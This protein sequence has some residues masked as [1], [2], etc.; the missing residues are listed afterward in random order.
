MSKLSYANLSP[1]ATSYSR[2]QE[3]DECPR[4]WYIKNALG[5]SGDVVTTHTNFAYG[6]AVATGIQH[7]IEKPE[8]FGIAIVKAMMQWNLPFWQEDTKKKKSI[9]FVIEVVRRF[10]TLINSQYANPFK[11]FELAWFEKDGKQIPAVELTFLVH[12]P[13]GYSYEG[14]IDLVL[15]EK[16]THNYVVL[17]L[18]TTSFT[19]LSPAIY[20]NSIQALGYAIVLDQIAKD[21]RQVSAY[22]V[23]YWVVKSSALEFQPFVFPKNFSKR[24]GFINHLLAKIEIMELYRELGYYPMHGQSCYSFFSDC[25]LLN[26]CEMSDETLKLMAGKKEDHQFEEAQT[27]P[28]FIFHWEALVHTQTQLAGQ[29]VIPAVQAS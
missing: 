8:E 20:Q 24:I 23:F 7:L 9:W 3:F 14:H 27:P 16:G 22:S 4:K 12:L 13:K 28:D 10:H 17:E 19:N 1:K 26:T 2:L 18:K 5:Y 15:R 29:K 21:T 6:H 11:N 25:E